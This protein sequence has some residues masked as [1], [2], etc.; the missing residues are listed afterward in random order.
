MIA[1]SMLG[2]RSSFI[3]PSSIKLR[4]WT[5]GCFIFILLTAAYFAIS[6]RQRYRALR[7]YS[8]SET[9]SRILL[10][11]SKIFMLTYF[12]LVALIF[13]LNLPFHV[14]APELLD[15]LLTFSL[16]RA[17]APAAAGVAVCILLDRAI[18]TMFAHFLSTLLVALGLA[19]I[20]AAST[21]LF[22]S[23][24]NLLSSD[25]RLIQIGFDGIQ[26]FIAGAAISA[27][28]TAIRSHYRDLGYEG[29]VPR[30]PLPLA[31]QKNSAA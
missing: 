22:L 5:A 2:E 25:A 18:A 3:L 24:M 21:L 6:L 8:S 14:N 31:S 11:L 9:N 28:A 7:T 12:I 30:I 27:L 26:F 1:S 13:I 20:S 10:S 17:L 23:E 4:I 29:G 16:T 15:Q 19:G